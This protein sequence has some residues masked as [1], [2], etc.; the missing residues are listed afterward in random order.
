M[1][2]N[3]TSSGFQTKRDHFV[4]KNTESDKFANISKSKPLQYQHH[5]H[6]AVVKK[7]QLPSY[8]IFYPTSRC[9]LSCSHCFYHDSL[10][11]RFNELSLNANRYG[12]CMNK[13]YFWKAKY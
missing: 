13:L 4:N 6:K 7:N 9:N 5:I 2:N 12:L 3:K 10:N 8:F 11:K 1:I